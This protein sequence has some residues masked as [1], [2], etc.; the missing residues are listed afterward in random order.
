M[1]ITRPQLARLQVLYNQLA[2]HETGVGR[3]RDS[4]LAW[5]SQRLHKPVSSFKNLT[6]DDAGFLIDNLQGYLQ[7]KA[8][9]KRRLD[10]DRARRA[11]LDGRKDG[12]EF[13]E[14]PQIVS[15]QDIA[16][17]QKLC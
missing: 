12:Q 7:V 6:A 13:A 10:R 1:Q 14:A 8:P 9:L 16:R 4:R 15:A 2:A 3:D 11:G 17:I 5:A